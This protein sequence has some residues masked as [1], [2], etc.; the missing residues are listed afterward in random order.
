[1]SIRSGTVGQRGDA[2][3]GAWLVQTLGVAFL[4]NRSLL[5]DNHLTAGFGAVGR[6]NEVVEVE[7][8][9]YAVEAYMTC[10]CGYELPINKKQCQ[11]E[12]TEKE[13][14]REAK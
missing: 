12:A 5:I 2:L 8:V 7:L 6:V 14:G 10:L 13:R 11:V 9:S 1:M 3:L 4:H